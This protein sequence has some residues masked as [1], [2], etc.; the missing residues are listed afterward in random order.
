M[1][2]GAAG[3][4]KHKRHCANCKHEGW[5]PDGS[6]C[7][8]PKVLEKHPHGRTLRGLPG[9]RDLCEY[10]ELPLFEDAS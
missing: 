4:P 10:P 2:G 6:Y 1:K 9:L 5:D 8:A 7:A 3:V